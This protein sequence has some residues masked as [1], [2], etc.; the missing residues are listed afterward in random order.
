MTLDRRRFL[1]AAGGFQHGSHLAFTGK[2]APPL[3]N[4][5][6]TLLR[7]LG[8]DAARFGSSTGALPG[9]EMT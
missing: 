5:Y 6:V 4:L 9:L 8:I 7:R 3:S 2:S 1:P